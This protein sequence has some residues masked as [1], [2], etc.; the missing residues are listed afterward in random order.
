MQLGRWQGRDCYIV[1]TAAGQR[2]SRQ[3]I[4]WRS[5][6]RRLAALLGGLPGAV[7][8]TSLLAG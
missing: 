4:G 1:P 7:M 2:P 5:I 3:P 8:R 6:S